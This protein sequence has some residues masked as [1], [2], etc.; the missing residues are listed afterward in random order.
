LEK[1]EVGKDPILFAVLESSN[2]GSSKKELDKVRLIPV[3]SVIELIGAAADGGTEWVFIN[4][5]TFIFFD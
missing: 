5:W 1:S 4:H 2:A 3:L